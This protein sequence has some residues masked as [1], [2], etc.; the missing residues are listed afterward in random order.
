MKLGDKLY[1]YVLLHIRNGEQFAGLVEVPADLSNED[2]NF[3]KFLAAELMQPKRMHHDTETQKREIDNLIELRSPNQIVAQNGQGGMAIVCLPLKV[4]DMLI[5]LR[6]AEVLYVQML[7]EKSPIVI[8]MRK[9]VTGLVD[10]SVKP[11]E[12]RTEGGII[13]PGAG[14]PK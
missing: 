11:G 5:T 10:P 12:E 2:K 13:L 6:A 8:E 3:K 4:G 9:A 7:D 1:Q 14:A